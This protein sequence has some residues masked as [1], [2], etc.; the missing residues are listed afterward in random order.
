M[1]T[2]YGYKER[3][4]PTKSMID[5]AGITKD[6]TDGIYAENKRR[7]EEKFTLDENYQAA[8]RA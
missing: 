2:Y 7:E 5:W 4:D 1:A 6:I 3:E 8:Q